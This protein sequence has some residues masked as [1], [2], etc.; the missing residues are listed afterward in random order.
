MDTYVTGR[1]MLLTLGFSQSFQVRISLSLPFS[2]Q[3]IAGLTDL[4]SALFHLSWIFSDPL[5]VSVLTRNTIH[6]AVAIEERFIVSKLFLKV[7]E[8]VF[9]LRVW[10]LALCDVED[11]GNLKHQIVSKLSGS[12]G[13]HFMQILVADFRS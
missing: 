6:C 2:P 11:V 3:S 12:A 5:V 10:S 7:L 1:S 9:V 4:R 13:L 8:E